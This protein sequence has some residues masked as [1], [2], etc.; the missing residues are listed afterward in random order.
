MLFILY[1]TYIILCQVHFKVIVV[2][3]YIV[4]TAVTVLKTDVV[5]TGL[6]V[7]LTILKPKNHE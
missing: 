6:N 2:I 5:K 1:S 7:D 4:P 3:G